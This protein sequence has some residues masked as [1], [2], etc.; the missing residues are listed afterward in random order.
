MEQLT[1]VDHKKNRIYIYFEGFLNEERAKR[2]HDA[3]KEAISQV[4]P[5][6]TVLTYSEN[7]KP[8]GP[9]VQ[10]I[11]S[12]M[13]QMAETGGCSKVAR[14]V[15]KTPLGGMQIN[16]LA[17]VTTSYASQHFSTEEEAEEYLNSDE[18]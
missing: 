13:V 14:V 16:R 17:K 5:G 18:V 4:Q 2:L 3:Y 15:G 1:R 12:K 8:G 11:V 9:E 7:Y 6:F 10:G